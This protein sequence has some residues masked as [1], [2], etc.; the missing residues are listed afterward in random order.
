[1]RLLYP[2]LGAL[3]I[4]AVFTALIWRQNRDLCAW[5]P[6]GSFSCG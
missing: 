4:L 5:A 6:T 3:A 2:T 1:M